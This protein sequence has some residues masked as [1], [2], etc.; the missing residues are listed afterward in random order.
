[1]K[2]VTRH[3]VIKVNPS[4]GYAFPLMETG[5]GGSRTV[6]FEAQRREARIASTLSA[7][8]SRPLACTDHY[9]QWERNSA[10]ERDFESVNNVNRV[11]NVDTVKNDKIDNLMNPE[12]LDFPPPEVIEQ[13]A[14]DMPPKP[15]LRE[16]RSAMI[17]LREKG[18]SYQEIAAWLSEKLG[19]PIKRNQVTYVVNT[20]PLVQDI[21]EREETEEDEAAERPV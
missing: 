17:S 8:L 9:S 1:M 16:Y 19:A 21:E 4:G 14:D 5:E 11:K 12:E 2:D 6:L 3:L 15:P 18:Y 20:D 13:A 10:G 7:K